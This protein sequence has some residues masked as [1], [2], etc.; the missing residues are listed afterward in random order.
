MRRVSG[1][2]RAIG[3]YASAMLDA[4]AGDVADRHAV[5]AHRLVAVRVG[6]AGLDGQ[7]G[8]GAGDALLA[9]RRSASRPTKS[10]LPKATNRSQPAW[11]GV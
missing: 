5:R 8:E 7:A 10:P 11:S 6:V 3:R 1:F 2:A 9:W 4:V